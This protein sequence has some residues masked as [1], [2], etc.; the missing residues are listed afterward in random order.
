MRYEKKFYKD[1]KSRPSS[2]MPSAREIRI[3]GFFQRE[4]REMKELVEER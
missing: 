2:S 3:H 4:V 1:Y